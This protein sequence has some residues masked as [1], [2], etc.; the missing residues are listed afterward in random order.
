MTSWGSA[1]KNTNRRVHF[2]DTCGTIL[3]QPKDRI[4]SCEVCGK[5][6]EVT[7]DL[8]R[9][10]TTEKRYTEDVDVEE[11]EH[12]QVIEEPCV[13][14]GYRELW[15]TTAQ[16]RSADEGSTVFYECISCHHK[17]SINN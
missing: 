9:P 11:I 16:L 10:V 5:E 14:C 13:R 3:D 2:C 4:I 6:T 1:L 15:F 8:F 12:R 7:E 17:W